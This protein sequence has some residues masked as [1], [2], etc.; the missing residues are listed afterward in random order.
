MTI[1]AK[2]TCILASMD[3]IEQAKYQIMWFDFLEQ[4][5]GLHDDAF[6]QNG[7]VIT[8]LWTDKR[9][10]KEYVKWLSTSLAEINITPVSITLEDYVE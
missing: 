10:A 7:T 8:R 2:T 9:C 6:V 4:L 3:D 5:G 1:V